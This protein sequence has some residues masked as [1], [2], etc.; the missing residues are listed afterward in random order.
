[1]F[2]LLNIEWQKIKNYRVFQV[3]SILY[4]VA[5]LLTTYISYEGFKG[6]TRSNANAELIATAFNPFEFPEFWSN[7]AFFLGLL[8]YFPC[9]IIITFCV[10]EFTFKTHR[11]NIIDGWSRTQFWAS[12]LLLIAI[13]SIVITLL[14]ILS[15]FVFSQIIKV[16]FKIDA[17]GLK[18]IAFFF[19]QTFYY[20][21][22]AFTCAIVFRK[23]GIAIM[24]FLL[25]AI[26]VE[27]ILFGLLQNYLSPGGYFLPLQIADVLTPLHVK[28]K[29][30]NSGSL[31]IYATAPDMKY[32]LL[33]FFGYIGLW[34]FIS[35][36]KFIKDDL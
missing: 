19:L 8:I 4:A 2:K 25:Y 28:D 22:V 23:S 35:Y 6:F 36:K 17:E 7:A 21:I 32:M 29:L 16:N 33:A 24:V 13:F 34:I 18:N 30:S 1:M 9:I 10:N 11:Q 14:Y 12:K 3:F 26:V 5:L 20:L 27:N 15:V 31:S